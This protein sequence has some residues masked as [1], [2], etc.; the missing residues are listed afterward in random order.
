MGKMK[1]LFF[2][3]REDIEAGELSFEEIAVKYSMTVADVCG[4]AKDL[5]AL[6]EHQS[7]MYE[8]SFE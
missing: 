4:Y 1:D 7:M 5:D 8:A 3:I 6:Y 2:D